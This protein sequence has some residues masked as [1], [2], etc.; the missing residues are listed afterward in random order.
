MSYGSGN[1]TYEL[2]EG[3]GT[4]P[5]GYEFNQVAAVDVDK[6]DQVYLFTRGSHQV[7][8]FDRDGKFLKS[9]GEKFTNPHGIHIGPDGNVYLADRDAH[10]ILKYSPD[11]R[12][13]LTL[14]TRDRPSDTGYTSEEKVVKRA[15]GPFNLPAGIAVS[16]EGDIFVADGYGNCEVHRFTADGGLVTSWGSPGSL[17]PSDLNLP[18]DTVLDHEGNV[19]VCDRENNRIQIFDPEEG[20]FLRMWTGLRQPAAVAV[21]PYGEVYVAEL[22]GRISVLDNDGQVLAQWGGEGSQEP[23]LFASPHG[24]AIDSHGDIYV[25]EGNPGNRVQKF[26]RQ[27]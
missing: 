17:N 19:L 15:G 4:L 7:M 2:A 25:G 13:L 18:H 12:L 14:G 22:Q 21:G 10:V 3:W 27:R 9:W 6:D 8:V 24:I 26:L 20:R 23:D 11:E 5:E 1:Y 16:S